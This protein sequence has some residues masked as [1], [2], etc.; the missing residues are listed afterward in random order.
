MA[1]EIQGRRCGDKISLGNSANSGLLAEN[2]EIS[3]R[4]RVRGGAIRTRTMDP[5][6]WVC[7]MRGEIATAR[8]SNPVSSGYS[9]RLLG[10]Q[11]VHKASQQ[12]A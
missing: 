8:S 3:V 7:E 11:R 1:L 9:W 4:S 10:R 5:L 6:G 2:R 12:I